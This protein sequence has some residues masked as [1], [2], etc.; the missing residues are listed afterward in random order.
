MDFQKALSRAASGKNG[1]ILVIRQA[2]SNAISRVLLD[3]TPA[4]LSKLSANRKIW[5]DATLEDIAEQLCDVAHK[6]GVIVSELCV[7]SEW[8][9]LSLREIVAEDDDPTYPHKLPTHKRRS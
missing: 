9:A 2:E 6:A 1:K 8:G 5:R 4:V 7:S 3:C